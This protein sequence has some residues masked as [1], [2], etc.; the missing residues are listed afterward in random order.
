MAK[1]AVPSDPGLYLSTHR[2]VQEI[3]SRFHFEWRPHFLLLLEILVEQYHSSSFSKQLYF[4]K[5]VTCLHSSHAHL[6]TILDTYI[7]HFHHQ[8]NHRFEL[9]QAHRSSHT[10]HPLTLLSSPPPLLIAL[11]LHLSSFAW[12]F[13]ISL[14]FFWFTALFFHF[15]ILPPPLFFFFFFLPRPSYWWEAFDMQTYL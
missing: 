15:F 3:F 6:F 4:T 12:F 13:F 7:S 5:H 10:A 14:Y 8:F 2:Y 11:P 9:T 1:R